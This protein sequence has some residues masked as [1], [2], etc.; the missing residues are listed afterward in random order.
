M[1]TL[2]GIAASPGI[3]I[4]PAFVITD[5]KF[6]LDKPYISQSEVKKE[7]E[8]FH[9]ALQKTLDEVNKTEE[10]VSKRLGSEYA[11]F[12]A[13]HKAI[14]HDP[15]LHEKVEKKISSE[16]MS[17]ENAV[18]TATA[19]ITSDFEKIK[20]EFFR[21]R[22]NDIFD[23][24]KKLLS[25]LSGRGKNTFANI[26]QPC[27]VIARNI[28]PSDTLKL[29][30]KPVLGFATDVGGKT[31]HTAI[32]AQNLE[33]PAVVGLSNVTKN[34]QTGQMVILDGEKGEIIISPDFDTLS[35]YKK[36]KEELERDEESLSELNS[37]E[38]VTTDG[39]QV[40]LMINFDPRRDSKQLNKM[41]SDGLGL[42]RT[43]FLFTDRRTPPSE[44]EQYDMYMY[45]ASRYD[46]RPVYIRLADLGGDKEQIL[47]MIE[48]KEEEN[49]FM[50]CRGVRLLLK[51]PSLMRTQIKAII[52]TAA[53]CDA[54]IK[55][56]VPMISTLEEVQQV[57]KVFLEELIS[58]SVL[59]INPRK[60]IDFGVMIEVPSAAIVVE[61][62][63]KE[64]DFISIG[65]NDL[66]QYMIAVDRVNQEVAS[67]YDA[68][69]P[70]ILRIINFITQAAR[71]AGK[72]VSVCGEL[73]ADPN[74]IPLLIGLGVNILSATPR[75]FWRVKKKVREMS[76]DT[77]SNIAQ[78]ALLMNSSEEIK[79]LS[80]NV[81]DENS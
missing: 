67:L 27:V 19:E 63:L 6:S 59:G 18:F 24:V 37:L 52:K 3:S 61:S 10:H 7:I 66:I 60:K 78:A 42:L 40:S 43:E 36:M 73:A 34:V 9:K 8:R 5:E 44:K 80:E 48:K 35:R 65:T 64:V 79:R 29:K 4:A 2:K 81:L 51:Y 68:Y 58:A 54:H 21:E 17:A 77:C 76:Y 32:L 25:N 12:L 41:R 70:A 57:K 49:P 28:F 13:V 46:T 72:Q 69:N 11:N 62:I 20:D 71:D 23:V 33:L 45:A 15:S 75:M 30:E 74:I 16:H 26:K 53:N 31:S 55:L 1:I 22:K 14:L 38:N 47:D 39:H 50:G 56:M